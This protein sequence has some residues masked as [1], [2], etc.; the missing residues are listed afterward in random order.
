MVCKM[1]KLWILIALTPIFSYATLQ[2]GWLVESQEP[3]EWVQESGSAQE[4]HEALEQR[5]GQKTLTKAEA[6]EEIEHQTQAQ[7]RKKIRKQRVAARKAL[8]RAQ[9]QYELALE[10]AKLIEQEVIK[11]REQAKQKA[12]KAIQLARKQLEKAKREYE[13]ALED[14]MAIEQQTARAEA[15]TQKKEQLYRKNHHQQKSSGEKNK[16]VGVAT[17]K[18]SHEFILKNQRAEE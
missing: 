12:V 13:L 15:P 6:K 10:D 5:S 14:P 17:K 18:Q 8:I 4:N 16:R 9:V 2:E 3:I 11:S 7:M 1:K